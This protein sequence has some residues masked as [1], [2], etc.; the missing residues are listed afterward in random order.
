MPRKKSAENKNGYQKLVWKYKKRREELKKDPFKKNYEARLRRINIR[1]EGFRHA[2][3]KIEKKEKFMDSVIE[4]IIEYNGINVLKIPKQ[5]RDTEK[6]NTRY[7]FYKY[8]I[9]HGIRGN[10]IANYLNQDNETA[11]RGRLFFTRSF[12]ENPKNREF[13]HRFLQYMNREN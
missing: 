1:L 6:I 12:N 9:E 11:I 13:Y 2:I 5:L 8:C 10:F 3:A 4:K 7:C